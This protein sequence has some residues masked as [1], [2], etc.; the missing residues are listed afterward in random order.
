MTEVRRVDGARYRRGV[1]LVNPVFVT[2]PDHQGELYLGESLVPV[3]VLVQLFIDG[4]L[5]KLFLK[6]RA[7]NLSRHFSRQIPPQLQTKRDVLE[8][9]NVR[10]E[11]GEDVGRRTDGDIGEVEL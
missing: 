9:N 7:V 11:A 10:V 4:E 2:A 5:V 8:A 3:P 1:Q 6:V